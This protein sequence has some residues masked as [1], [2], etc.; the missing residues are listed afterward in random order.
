MLALSPQ[1][2][3]ECLPQQVCWRRGKTK[4]LRVKDCSETADEFD[5]GKALPVWYLQSAE[6]GCEP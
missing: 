5:V 6:T 2:E 1:E 3:L 4:M